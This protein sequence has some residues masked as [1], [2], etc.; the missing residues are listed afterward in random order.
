MRAGH[1]PAFGCSAQV[2]SRFV[3]ETGE[4]LVRCGPYLISQQTEGLLFSRNIPAFS[5]TPWGPPA[6]QVP[7]SLDRGCDTAPI[8]FSSGWDREQKELSVRPLKCYLFSAAL[9]LCHFNHIVFCV[10]VLPLSQP[11]RRDAALP[12]RSDTR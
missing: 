9:G 11:G 4:I 3:R 6:C 10:A 2:K 7:S 12:D 5:R 8:A 1:R